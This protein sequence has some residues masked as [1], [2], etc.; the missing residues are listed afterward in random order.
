MKACKH[1]KICT[2]TGCFRPIVARKPNPIAH[3]NITETEI[4]LT[5]G[6]RRETKMQKFLIPSYPVA[7]QFDDQETAATSFRE[8]VKKL[9]EEDDDSYFGWVRCGMGGGYA[10]DF[11]D[12]WEL[13]PVEECVF[14]TRPAGNQYAVLA[15]V[16]KEWC[17]ETSA[18]I[19]ARSQVAEWDC[20]AVPCSSAFETL[21][22]AKQ[23]VENLNAEADA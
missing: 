3:G 13:H 4:C 20:E 12:D 10:V 6:A 1:T 7:G 11:A 18:Q 5:C 14:L 22:D 8:M 9:V 16:A 2:H 23:F 21:E 17:G 19:N 15:D